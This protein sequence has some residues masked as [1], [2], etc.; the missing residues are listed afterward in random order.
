MSS[1]DIAQL[2]RI[3]LSASKTRSD[4]IVKFTS[5]PAREHLYNRRMN[6]KGSALDGVFVNRDLTGQLSKILFKARNAAKKDEQRFQSAWSADGKIHIK[7]LNNNIHQAESLENLKVLVAL[8]KLKKP[9]QKIPAPMG[10][11]HNS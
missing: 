7:D 1:S 2:H 8:I 9:R 3:G 10:A 6:L 11:V 4:I 5:Y